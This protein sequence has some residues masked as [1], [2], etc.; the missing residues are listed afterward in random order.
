[1]WLMTKYGFYSA[2]ADRDRPD[3]VV[4]RARARK[5]LEQLCELGGLD[6]DVI[7]GP[8]SH[9]DYRWRIFMGRDRWEP[10]VGQLVANIDYPNFKSA[11]GERDPRRAGIYGNVWGELLQVQLD[12]QLPAR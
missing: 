9:S 11:V 6:P 12:E 4:V 8:N 7:V 2:V 3:G 10:L 5:D 1:M